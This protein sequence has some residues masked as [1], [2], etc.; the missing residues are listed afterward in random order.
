M[1]I[2]AIVSG[3]NVFFRALNCETF[4]KFSNLNGPRDNKKGVYAKKES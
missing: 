3:K 2:F 4:T 1:Q